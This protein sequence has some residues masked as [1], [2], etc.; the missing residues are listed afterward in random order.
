LTVAHVFPAQATRGY[1]PI[2]GNLWA[3]ESFPT[4]QRAT[5]Y[6]AVNVIYQLTGLIIVPIATAFDGMSSVAL[7]EVYA[8]IQLLLGVFTMFLPNETTNKAL[9]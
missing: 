2:A 6:A 5:C 3:L 8:G 9:A 7:I 1:A 4:E